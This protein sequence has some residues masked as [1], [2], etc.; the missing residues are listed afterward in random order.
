MF[1]KV[2]KLIVILIF[3][4]FFTS[5]AIFYYMKGYIFDNPKSCKICHIMKESCNSWEKSTHSKVT[6]CSDCHMLSKENRYITGMKT[7]FH[8]TVNFFLD[9]YK[10]PVSL[11][12]EKLAIVEGNCYKCHT[13][14]VY[15]GGIY[16][17]HHKKKLECN[18]CH[19]EMYGIKNCTECHN[20]SSHNRM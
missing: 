19:Y 8:H 4:L 1:K 20:K 17:I 16:H 13:Y 15:T 14:L 2:K 5:T 12:H 18:R 7:G 6:T 9:R 11:T 3:L 10:K